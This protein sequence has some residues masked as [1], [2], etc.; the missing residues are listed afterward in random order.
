MSFIIWAR[1]TGRILGPQA[2]PKWA[3][4]GPRPPIETL[5]I[6]TGNV[7]A[8]ISNVLR[9]LFLNRY[10]PLKSPDE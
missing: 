8:M 5:K 4:S 3:V 1:N 7:E 10:Q 6:H 2:T 9:D